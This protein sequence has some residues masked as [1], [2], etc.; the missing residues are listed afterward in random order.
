MANSNMRKSC[1][2]CMLHNIYSL[3]VKLSPYSML[4]PPHGI[5][6]HTKITP[7][8]LLNTRHVPNHDWPSSC[9][10]GNG[11]LFEARKVELHMELLVPA[12]VS[13][14]FPFLFPHLHHDLFYYMTE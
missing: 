4:H 9:D 10:S 1:K 5:I 7:Q 11:G 12:N 6:S 3:L 13:F 2:L 14:F 8:P